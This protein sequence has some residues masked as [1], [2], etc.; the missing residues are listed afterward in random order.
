MLLMNCV[1]HLPS[2]T[3]QK[4]S[5]NNNNYLMAEYKEEHGEKEGSVSISVIICN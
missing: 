2:N 3:F 5:K 4:R 1:I